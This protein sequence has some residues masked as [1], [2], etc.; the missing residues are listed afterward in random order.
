MAL[1]ERL[2]PATRLTEGLTV[3]I[4]GLTVGFAT[5]TAVSGPLI[6]AH[7]ASAGFLVMIACSVTAAVVAVLGTPYLDRSM[8]AVEDPVVTT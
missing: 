8:R 2:V 7:G 4:A 3:G 5:G 1:I 6:D